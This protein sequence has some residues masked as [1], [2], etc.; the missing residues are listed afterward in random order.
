MKAS[1][2]YTTT[3][4]GEGYEDIYESYILDVNLGF[5]LF[6]I[7]GIKPFSVL[8]CQIKKNSLMRPFLEISL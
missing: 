8:E 5:Y 3:K 4:Q 7:E 2:T 6:E 1:W